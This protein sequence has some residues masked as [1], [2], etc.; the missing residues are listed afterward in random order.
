MASIWR[1]NG[2]YNDGVFWTCALKK[3]GQV[4]M[5]VTEAWVRVLYIY[6]GGNAGEVYVYIKVRIY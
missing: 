5:R 3:W 6:T 1:Q 2:V 4:F